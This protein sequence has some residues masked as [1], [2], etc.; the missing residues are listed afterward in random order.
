MKRTIIVTAALLAGMIGGQAANA[1]PARQAG[2]GLP[3]RHHVAQSYCRQQRFDT[4][5]VISAVLG[6]PWT[7]GRP[8]PLY[9]GG[10]RVWVDPHGTYLPSQYQYNPATDGYD[11]Q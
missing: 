2:A 7:V 8:A 4:G 10:C 6:A 1:M 9:V 3:T 5:Q 11:L